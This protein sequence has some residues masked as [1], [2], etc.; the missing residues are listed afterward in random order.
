MATNPKP[1]YVVMHG[2]EQQSR[3]V[4]KKKAQAIAE[5]WK[6][7]EGQDA[8][9]VKAPKK[10]NPAD[11]AALA[12]KGF[13]GRD[14]EEIVT[15]TKQVH[16]HKHLASCGKL[17]RID[18]VPLNGGKVL[19]TG[20]KGALLAFNEK[21]TQLFAEGGDQKVDLRQFGIAPSN[22]H[23]TETL[24]DVVAVE[25]FT[26]KDHLGSE[27]GTAVFRHKFSKPYPQLIYDVPNEQLFFSGGKYIVPD[28]GIDQ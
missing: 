18:V 8:R 5:R 14:T 13:H 16:Y 19:L 20:F 25:Y 22:A 3:P 4:S 26:T 23:E 11:T 10:G 7:Y 1:K 27:G 6:G 15:V 28:E 9:V 17:E 12:Y 21:R 2:G 24:G